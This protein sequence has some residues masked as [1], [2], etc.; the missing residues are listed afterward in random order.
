MQWCGFLATGLCL[1]VV[2]VIRV[3]QAILLRKLIETVNEAQDADKWKGYVFAVLLGFSAL[4]LA[5][6]QHNFQCRGSMIGMRMRVACMTKAHRKLLRLS[7]AGLANTTSGQ[8]VNLVAADVR[9]FDD[10]PLYFHYVWAAPL[11]LLAVALLVGSQ[12][13]WQPALAGTCSLVAFIP[14]QAFF[15]RQLARCRRKTIVFADSRIKMTWEVLQGILG[16]KIFG[17]EPAFAASISKIRSN[18]QQILVR[19]AMVRAFNEA[20]HFVVHLIMALV[21]FATT[22]AVGGELTKAKVFFAVSLF[23]LP[24]L[25]MGSYFPLAI[26]KISECYVTC[27]RLQR[28]L[29]IKEAQGTLKT[30][31]HGLSVGVRAGTLDI[32]PPPSMVRREMGAIPSLKRLLS[33]RHPVVGESATGNAAG[34]PAVARQVSI[35]REVGPIPVVVN[36]NADVFKRWAS[37]TR[38]PVVEIETD[39]APAGPAPPLTAGSASIEATPLPALHPLQTGKGHDSTDDGGGED[40]GV[41]PANGWVPPANGWVP[42]ANGGVPPANGGV[43]PANGGVPPA[44]GGVP[45]PKEEDRAASVAVSG[46]PN[47]GV[48]VQGEKGPQEAASPVH[49]KRVVVKDASFSWGLEDDSGKDCQLTGITCQIRDR[50]LLAVTGKIGAGKSSFLG[51]LLGEMQLQRGGMAVRGRLSF[52]SQQPFI[53]AGTVRD[54]I[55]FGTEYNK[56]R[57]ASVV[58]AAALVPDLKALP[59]GDMTE[60]SERG[61]NMSGGMLARVALARAAYAQSDIVLLDDPLSAVDPEV[62][63]H[64]FTRCIKGIL[65]DRTVVL[66]THQVQFLPECDFIVVMKQGRIEHKGTFEALKKVVDFSQILDFEAQQE[67]KAARERAARKLRVPSEA[68]GVDAVYMSPRSKVKMAVRRLSMSR[69]LQ[70]AAKETEGIME[71]EEP[72]AETHAPGM[73]LRVMRAYASYMGWLALVPI[74]VLMLTGQAGVVLSYWFLNHWS[75]STASRQRDLLW[76]YGLL[77]GVT[78]LV[79]YLR[80]IIFFYAAV[81][82]SSGLH[83]ASLHRILRAPLSFSHR[84]PPARILKAF[85]ADQAV[86]DDA[87]PGSLFRYW[88]GHFILLGA[89]VMVMMGV[90]WVALL[91]FPLFFGVVWLWKKTIVVSLRNVKRIESSTRTLAVMYFASSLQGLTTIH[92]F[93]VQPQFHAAYINK[94]NNHSRSVYT[95]QVFQRWFYSRCES[96]LQLSS[97]LQSVMRLHTEVE[98][99]VMSTVERIVDYTQLKQEAALE[100]PETKPPKDWPHAGAIS[101][102]KLTVKY[103]TADEPALRDISLEIAAGSKCGIVGR[104]GSGKSSLMLALFRLL[105]PVQGRILID[106]IDTSKIGLHDLRRKIAAIPQD[107][108]LFGESLRFNLDPFSEYTE[109]ETWKALEAAQ[110][111]AKVKGL[112]GGLYCMMADF[113][114]SFSVGERQLLCMARAILH[115]CRILIMDEATANADFETDFHIQQMLMEMFV[116][117]TVLVIAHRMDTIIDSDTVLVLDKGRMAEYGPPTILLEKPDGALSGMVKKTSAASQSKLRDRALMSLR[118]RGVGAF[119][120]RQATIEIG[121]GIGEEDDPP[122]QPDLIVRI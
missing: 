107:P 51:A 49:F 34:A 77:I 47:V 106:G 89:L 14:L 87:L 97:T 44:N 30:H 6:I 5:A 74:T 59:D 78:V 82:A 68:D 92:A 102:Q 13:G 98:S 99:H 86:L 61:T 116:G 100:V 83:R 73:K 60:L 19:S 50:Q 112:D 25:W 41:P 119:S 80:A 111:K 58:A 48:L 120:V 94:L 11:E 2:S 7:T 96:S 23:N 117:T 105:E 52:I 38:V 15:G 26:E 110:L 4:C 43:P 24:R 35:R 55:L 109:E 18:E 33:I 46:A 76:V 81:R 90:P 115:K 36:A 8:C 104:T 101:I 69:I 3:S 118:T 37:S 85:S 9:R 88:Q 84:N 45:G 20:L 114:D 53:M 70:V 12:L 72:K 62:A 121:E 10:G 103:D 29:L 113:G 40:L 71:N 66:V 39:P 75:H 79:S 64:L 54:N 56:R 67:A 93:G 16:V 22:I 91:I 27:Q 21:T 28:F 31:S 17:W 122:N 65:S 108:I 95:A 1:L 63:R 57:Y 32:S 42:P